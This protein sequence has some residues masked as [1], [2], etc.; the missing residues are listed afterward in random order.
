M[1]ESGTIRPVGATKERGV[2]VRILAATHRDLRQLVHRG[3]FREDLFY[4]L[5]V[6]TLEIPALRHRREDIPLL[7]DHF[8]A[9]YRA[10]TPGSPVERLSPEALGAIMDHSWPGNVREL[11]HV[12]ERLVLLGRSSVI[13]RADLPAAILAATSA[14]DPPSFDGAIV[15]IRDLQRRYAA[16]AFEQMAGNKARAA[17]RLGVDVKTLAKWLSEEVEPPP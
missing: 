2:D 14:R 3:R 16:W 1:L 10:K 4:R 6:V 8:L 12:L 17:E 11:A 13:L 7:A 15:P 9:R 5:D